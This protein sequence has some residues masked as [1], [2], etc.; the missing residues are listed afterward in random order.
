MVD[1]MFCWPKLSIDMSSFEK[2][3]ENENLEFKAQNYSI[4]VG[5][6][7]DIYFKYFK[8]A[9]EIKYSYGMTNILENQYNEYDNYIKSLS[10]RTVLISLTFE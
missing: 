7:V 4:D 10:T 5:F 3:S 8:F 6:G 9:P 1:Y 2:L